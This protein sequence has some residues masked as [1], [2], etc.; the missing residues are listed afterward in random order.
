MTSL[1]INTQEK[2]MKKALFVALLLTPFVSSVAHAT[3]ACAGNG[4][5][6][7]VPVD[8]AG[9]VKKAFSAKCSANVLSNY[10]QNNVA[11]GVVAGSQKG[12]NV[13]GGGTGGGGVKATGTACPATGCTTGE[14]SDTASATQRDSS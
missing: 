7:D 6:V 13:F 3:A 8:S 10:S 12:K 1:V 5:A 9:Y 14:I 11:F 2:M 4:L